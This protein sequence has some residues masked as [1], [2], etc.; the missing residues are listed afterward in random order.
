[1][2]TLGASF[3]VLNL[4]TNKGIASLVHYIHPRQGAKEY[5]LGASFAI[6]ILHFRGRMPKGKR[7]GSGA[8]V[9]PADKKGIDTRQSRQNHQDRLPLYIRSFAAAVVQKEADKRGYTETA[10]AK[11]KGCGMLGLRGSFQAF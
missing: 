11:N 6:W 9:Q 5:T 2:Y 3:A 1:M 7:V 4:R 10:I 8:E